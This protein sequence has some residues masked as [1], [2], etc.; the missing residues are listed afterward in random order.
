MT[1]G[2]TK[3]SGRVAGKLPIVRAS[4]ES[5]FVLS[6]TSV[7]ALDTDLDNDDSHTRNWWGYV[8]LPRGTMS[9]EGEPHYTGTI[10]ATYRDID[11]VITAIRKLH[12]VPDWVNRLLGIGPYNVDAIGT[13]GK[14]TKLGLVDARAH[15]QGVIGHPHARVRATYDGTRDPSPWIAEI[16]LGILAVGIEKSGDHLGIQLAGVGRWFDDKVGIRYP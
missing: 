2:H 4:S 13:F 10:H 12:G 5:N 3:L 1:F 16:D 9:F 15:A 6:G 8:Q 7:R 14:H 11:P